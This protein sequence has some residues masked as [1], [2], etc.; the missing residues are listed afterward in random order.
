M[1]SARFSLKNHRLGH[2]AVRSST[3]CLLVD[4][5]TYLQAMANTPS[6]RSSICTETFKQFDD[7]KLRAANV[8][9]F[10]KSRQIRLTNKV[11]ILQTEIEVCFLFN[12]L[13]E[14]L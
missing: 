8:L 4:T 7:L 2:T 14:R 13:E 12:R 5:K 11:E 9:E 6:S 1:E 10:G 3:C